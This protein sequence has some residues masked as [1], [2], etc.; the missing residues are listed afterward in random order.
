MSQE[1]TF[2]ESVLADY[3]PWVNGDATDYLT[4]LS[5]M[6]E[7]TY[8]IVMDQGDPDDPDYSAGWSTLLDPDACPTAFLP[9]LAQFI[10]ATVA[11]G[12]DDATARAEILNAN[13]LTRGT[14]AAMMYGAAK[15]LTGSQAVT[16]IERTA[17]NGTPDAYHVILAV[18]QSQLLTNLQDLI[19]EV[20]AA[21]PAGIQV[22]YEA[23]QGWAWNTAIHTWNAET[24]TWNGVFQS[25]P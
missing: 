20:E 3:E 19:N 16:L 5:Q 7:L 4:A 23:L 2:T 11:P 22:T 6:F 1:S 9:F 12:T 21:K 14:P 13:N 15:H 25:Q 24:Q 8:S 17:N 18:Q 10:G